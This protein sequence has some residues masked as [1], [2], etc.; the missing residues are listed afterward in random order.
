MA[1][2]K[3][4]KKK[5]PHL[6]NSSEWISAKKQLPVKEGWVLA[7]TDAFHHYH[8]CM[9]VMYSR[10]DFWLE[11]TRLTDLVTHWMPLPKKPEDFKDVNVFAEKSRN[12]DV[13]G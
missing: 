13:G 7:W 1:S 6:V 12:E 4:K 2:K 10:L 9:I 8:R 3:P 5:V 11:G